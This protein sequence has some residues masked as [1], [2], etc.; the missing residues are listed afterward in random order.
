MPLHIMDRPEARSSWSTVVGAGAAWTMA[1]DVVTGTLLWGAAGYGLDR[2]FSTRPWF[3]LGGFI[4]GHT[5]GIYA[6]ILHQKAMQNRN[7]REE[8]RDR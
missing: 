4:V 7:R 3:M 2:L 8:V 6:A 5:T 1:A